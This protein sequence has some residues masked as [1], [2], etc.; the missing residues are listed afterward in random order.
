MPTYT[1]ELIDEDGDEIQ[2]CVPGRYEV[3]TRCHGVGKHDHPAFSNGFTSEDM[4]ED[5]DFAEEYKAGRYDV[6]CSKCHG[7]RVV[8]VPDTD[9]L[10]REQKSKLREHRAT[11]AELARDEASER[12]LRMLESGGY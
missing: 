9:R 12:H 8:C 5:P 6:E 10:T 1:F 11:V 4:A 3:C 7:K 2:V